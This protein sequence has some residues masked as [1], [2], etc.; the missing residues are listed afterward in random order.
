VSR[1][2]CGE[3]ADLLLKF[4]AGRLDSEAQVRLNRHLDVCPAC[5]EFAGGQ[6][7]VWDSLDAWE[8]APVS[9]DFDRRLYARIQ[10]E[11]SWWNR[12]LAPFR[13]PQIRKGWPI[14]AAA[15]LVLVAGIVVVDRSIM[16]RPA[17]RKTSIQVESLR[18]DQAQNA[19]EDMEM[20]QEINGLVGPAS[21]ASKM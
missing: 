1:I 9:P 6:K 5:R 7:A 14:A 18:P 19:I 21:A 15:W 8:M 10:G 20:L 2:D 16:V 11:V 4:V 17:P 3:N 12:I 13:P